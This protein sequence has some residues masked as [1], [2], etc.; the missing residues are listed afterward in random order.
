[1]AKH[2][3]LAVRLTEEEY[4]LI[5]QFTFDE[6]VTVSEFFRNIVIPIVTAHTQR[7]PPQVKKI[8]SYGS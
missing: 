4:D 6:G 3:R 8:L 7:K 1:M 5:K 2:K